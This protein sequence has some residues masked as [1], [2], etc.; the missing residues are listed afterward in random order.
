MYIESHVIA[1][2]LYIW[3]FSQYGAKVQG[4][5]QNQTNVTASK[6]PLHTKGNK[7]VKWQP[8]HCSLS[9]LPSKGS[10]VMSLL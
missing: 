8:K 5:K 2:W 10:Y 3:Q 4:T 1:Q 9:M 7:T 6:N